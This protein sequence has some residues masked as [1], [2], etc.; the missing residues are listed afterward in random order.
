VAGQ[1]VAI[2]I[3]ALPDR[4]DNGALRKLV[5]RREAHP[6]ADPAVSEVTVAPPELVEG[7]PGRYWWQALVGEGS[8]QVAGPV[9]VFTITLPATSR[10]RSTIPKSTGRHAHYGIYLSTALI[11]D[12]VGRSTFGELART[13]AKRWGLTPQRW[14]GARAG[15]MD[16][17][18]IVGFGTKV[19]GS[20]LGVERDLV[21]RVYRRRE[22]CLTLR[23]P[24]GEVVGRSCRPLPATYVGR[25]VLERDVTLRRD[26]PWSIRP[27]AP[28]INRYDLETVLLHELGH[29]AGNKSH[30]PRCAN[31]PMVVSLSA[32]EW[33][34]TPLDHFQFGCERASAWVSAASAASVGPRR[35]R[36][37][38]RTVV[39]GSVIE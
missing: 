3:S 39:V 7:R 36:L 30:R 27:D 13:S 26:V 38:H 29:L 16:G 1:R 37:V 2:A 15:R 5:V 28:D 9:G 22:Q 32:G 25:R 33:W 8:E 14:T 31:S 24:E 35:L 11:P 18:S 6:G 10:E 17:W 19:G 20:E 34:H 4:D 23:G 21:V 12:S